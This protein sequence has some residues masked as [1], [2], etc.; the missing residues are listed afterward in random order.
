MTGERR[1]APVVVMGVSA[2]GKSTIGRGLAFR[3][4]AAFVDADDLH[5]DSN[6]A[7]MR[8]G[9]PLDDEDRR[10]WLDAVGAVLAA[11]DRAASVV[12]A[13]SALRRRYR[14]RLLAHAPEVRF[15]HLD[16]APG[17]LAER[18]SSRTGHFMPPGLLASQLATL[19]TLAPDEPG[20]RVD[21][22]APVHVIVDA[23]SAGLAR[24][25]ATRPVRA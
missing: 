1:P 20:F 3:L 19:E 25:D 10:P 5:P 14:E 2:A 16:A 8:A 12:V 4:G 6:R 15:V 23:A 9:V 22:D 24:L 17:V 18:A 21:V 13:C 11:A 7:K